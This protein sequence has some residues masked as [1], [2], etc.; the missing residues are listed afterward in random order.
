MEHLKRLAVFAQVVESGSMTAAARVLEMTPSAVSQ[1][2]RQLEQETGVVLLHRS[3]RQLSLTAVGEGVYEHCREML[4]S[5]RAAEQ[6]L[7]AQQDA[8]SGELR[9]ASTI[10]FAAHHLG[11]ALAPLLHD[12]PQLG[13]R[14][15]STNDP[16]DLIAERV[17]LALRLGEAEDSN[18]VAR[19]LGSLRYVL[20]AAPAYLARMGT[21]AEPEDLQRHQMLILTSRHNP[22]SFPFTHVNSGE[23]RELVLPG[24]ILGNESQAL[25]MM[26]RQGLGLFHRFELDIQSELAEGSL[27]RVLPQWQLPAVNLYA[28]TSS[29]EALPAKVR[30]AIQAIRQY[31]HQAQRQDAAIEVADDW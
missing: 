30:Y 26:N 9:I 11:R 23:L 5:A 13:L 18:Q 2:I 27:V 3:T 25:A 20:C 19:R 12:Y 29:R 8:P 14:L 24:R 22:H 10:M 21:P 1:Q 7:A 4:L 16:V 28:V 15:L 6:M 31:L 17:D